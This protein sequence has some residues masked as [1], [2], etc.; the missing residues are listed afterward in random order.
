MVSWVRGKCIGKGSFGT[1]NV[2]VKKGSGAVFAVKSVDKNACVSAQIESLENEI[3]I[4][5]SLETSPYVVDYLGDDESYESPTKLYRNLHLEHLPGGTVADLATTTTA[6]VDDD[7]VLRSHVYCIV[8]ALRHIHSNGIVHCDVKGKNILVSQNSSLCKLVDFGSAKKV[9]TCRASVSPRGSPLWMAPE[10]VRGECQGPESDVWSLGCTVLEIV[11]GKPA[12]DCSGADTLSRIGFSDELPQFPTRLSEL[13][14]DFLEKCL[15]RDPSRRWSCDRLLQHPFLASVSPPTSSSVNTPTE[16]SPRCVLDWVDSEFEEE[17]EE[18]EDIDV[19]SF[20]E[21]AK[22]RIGKLAGSSGANWDSDGW[23]A[24]REYYSN[25]TRI[26][27]EKTAGISS[28]YSDSRRVNSE[29]EKIVVCPS[30]RDGSQMVEFAVEMREMGFYGT[31]S[32]NLFLFSLLLLSFYCST[33]FRYIL[34]LFYTIFY[35]PGLF[36]FILLFGSP[37]SMGCM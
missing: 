29:K 28:A 4:L 37:N 12:W 30:C 22:D 2:A 19:E 1:V 9:L 8:S 32:N 21:S 25:S 35:I 14:R 31:C 26:E 16:S 13:G 34:M 24:V 10:V 3:R 7:R 20:E 11:T 17:E 15:R 23:M 36:K 5:Q 27:G 18:E 33:I 6:Y